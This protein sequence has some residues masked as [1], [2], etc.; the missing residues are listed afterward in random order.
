MFEDMNVNNESEEGIRGHKVEAY[1]KLYENV[2][3]KPVL[4]YT[5]YISIKT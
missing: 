2:F 1:G 5:E 4:M 3:V